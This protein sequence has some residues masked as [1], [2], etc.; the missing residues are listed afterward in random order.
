MLPVQF[1][2]KYGP[3]GWGGGGGVERGANDPTPEKSTVTKPGGRMEDQGGGEEPY[4]IA[5][6]VKKKNHKHTA[7][8]KPHANL[9]PVCA[10]ESDQ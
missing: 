1:C 6:P 5:A 9:E 8:G 4:R 7:V 10:L 2:D 3:P